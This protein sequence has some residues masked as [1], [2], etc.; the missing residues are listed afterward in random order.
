MRV[1][2]RGFRVSEPRFGVSE[3]R[4]ALVLVSTCAAPDADAASARAEDSA[5]SPPLL[6]QMSSGGINWRLPRL[7]ISGRVLRQKVSLQN[8][9]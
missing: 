8:C 4:F 1:A 7:S 2:K 5:L 9:W 3:P 6:N